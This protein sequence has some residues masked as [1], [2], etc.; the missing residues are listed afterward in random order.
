MGLALS[1]GSFLVLIGDIAPENERGKFMSYLLGAIFLGSTIGPTI[2]GYLTE[3]GGYRLPFFGYF[4][5]VLIGLTLTYLTVTET[6]N[7][8]VKRESSLNDFFKSVRINATD[9]LKERRIVIG[10]LIGLILFTTSGIR[11]ASVP[12]YAENVLQLSSLEIGTVFS[13]GAICNLITTQ[14]SGRISDRYGR[15]PVILAGFLMFGVSSILF[16]YVKTFVFF[17]FINALFMVSFGLVNTAQQTLSIDFT[18]PNRRG[19]FLGIYRLGMDF[20][21]MVGPLIA[22]SLIDYLGYRYPFFAITII[23][24][25]ISSMVHFILES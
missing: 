18:D 12:L 8:D 23:S 21:M 10:F 1:A 9:M 20:G 22:G 7:L 3:I 19:S 14:I 5:V 13:I 4:V 2:G 15:K 16:I 6:L 25:I 17:S 24:F 11:S